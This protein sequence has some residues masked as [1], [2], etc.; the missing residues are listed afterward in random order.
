MTDNWMRDTYRKLHLDYHQP[1]WMGNVAGAFTKEEAQKQVALFQKAKIEAVSFF[2]YDHYG[3]AFY[4]SRIAPIHP[5]LKGDYTGLMTE[6]L[7]EAGLRVTLYLAALTSAH[8]HATHEDWL[9]RTETNH[10]PK[11]AWLQEEASHLCVNSPFVDEFMVPLIKE[12]IER[13]QPD[14]VWI[15]AGAWMIDTPC[16]CVHCQERYRADT[17][18]NL[19]SS[20]APKPNDELAD[21]SW[22]KWRLW[23]RSRINVYINKLV[24]AVR[25]ASPKT[26]IADNNLGKYFTGVPQWKEGKVERWLSPQDFGVDYLSCDPVAMGGNHEVVLSREGRYQ[27]TIG[28][29]YEYMNER[30][31]AWGEWQCRP[32]LDWKLEAATMISVGARCVFADQPYPNGLVEPRVY[33]DLREVYS[34]VEER[35]PFVKGAVPVPDVAILAS[36]GANTV[37]PAGGALWGRVSAWAD[38]GEQRVDRVDG[39]HLM[40]VELGLQ[41]LIYDEINLK[42]AM[43]RQR[44]I[45]VPDQLLLDDETIHA[46]KDYVKNGGRLLVTGRS[47][48]YRADGTIR[49]SDPLADVLGLERTAEQVSPIHYLKAGHSLSG[50]SPWA[51]I[52]LQAWGAASEVNLQGAEVLADSWGPV[53]D[54]W[55][56]GVKSKANWQHYTVFGAAPIGDDREGPALTQHRYGLG[57]AVYLN[58]DL[59]ALYYQEGHRLIRQWI[60]A[61]VDRLYADEQRKVA[62]QKPLHVEVSLMEQPHLDRQIVHLTNFFSQKRPG[63]TVHN[64]EILPVNNIKVS[65]TLGNRQVER[66][67]LEPEGLELSYKQKDGSIDIVVPQLDIHAMLCVQL[68]KEE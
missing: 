48:L 36:L 60:L 64:E 20:P 8:L 16:W 15:D 33:E 47:G 44:L 65:L 49:E 46:L 38:M 32:L 24:A 63:N 11:G 55:K 52:P 50:G 2:A 29:P 7:R 35:E 41:H 3:Q 23:K 14:A 53:T 57:T 13:H 68:S 30:F 43:D 17:G 61:I 27:S 1:P 12:T 34:F 10:A 40:F 39:A 42:K 19:P 26:L 9:V 62:V 31:H 37:G 56:D 58:V 18:L 54:V 5:G 45:V 6:A 51:D 4:P 28:L 25:E 59:F 22:L 21:E 67:T 66:V